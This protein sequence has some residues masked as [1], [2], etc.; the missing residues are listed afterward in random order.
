MRIESPKSESK[1]PMS[2]GNARIM[3]IRALDLGRIHV[4]E[5]FKQR[6]RERSFTTVDAERIIRHGTVD[7]EP[8]EC[9]KFKNW[10]F[11]L[12]GISCGQVLEI[13]VGLSMELDLEFP[14]LAFITGISKGRGKSCKSKRPVPP[15]RL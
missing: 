1:F 6:A 2:L 7:G 8:I 12:T 14:V 9:P 11:K 15:R 5:H 13:Y 10:R 4:T 3:L